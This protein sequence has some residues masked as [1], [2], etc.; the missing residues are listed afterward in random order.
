LRLFVIAFCL[1]FNLV[2]DVAGIFRGPA[3][4][5]YNMPV[6]MACVP[7]RDCSPTSRLPAIPVVVLGILYHGI[8]AQDTSVSMMDNHHSRRV[9]IQSVLW[10]V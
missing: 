1:G 8:A 2:R 3:Q 6:V 7:F 4:A 9:L 5:Q 10:S